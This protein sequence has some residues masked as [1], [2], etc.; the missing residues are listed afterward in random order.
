MGNS[1]NAVETPS[2]TA[3]EIAEAA[4]VSVQAV[5]GWCRRNISRARPG[6]SWVL[7]G[8]DLVRACEHYGVEIPG[9][10]EETEW[11]DGETAA[12]NTGGVDYITV[13]AEVLED[14]RRQLRE[15][16]EQ[17]QK[18]HDLIEHEQVLRAQSA[19]PELPDAEQP[20]KVS[21]WKR[22]WS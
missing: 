15:K 2:M 11:K 8:T 9:N 3:A 14:L 20:P 7:A 18:L 19:I 1:R 10:P 21:W 17:I 5:R 12:Q 13:P 22:L 16:D 4:G 6:G